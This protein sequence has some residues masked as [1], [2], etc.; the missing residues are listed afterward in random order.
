[1]LDSLLAAPR[2]R[3]HLSVGAVAHATDFSWDRTA[4]G[5]LRVYRESVTEHRALIAARLEKAFVW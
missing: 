4:E 3:R 2:H 5:L 1:V